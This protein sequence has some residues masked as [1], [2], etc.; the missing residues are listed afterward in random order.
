MAI[1]NDVATPVGARDVRNTISYIFFSVDTSVFTA[2]RLKKIID[3][4]YNQGKQQ[5]QQ[6]QQL[7][8]K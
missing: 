4:S 8:S 7:G 5:Q 3:R 2:V 6:Q 1:R